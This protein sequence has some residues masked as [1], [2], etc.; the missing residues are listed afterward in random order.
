MS[1]NGKFANEEELVATSA[2]T[3]NWRGILIALL[4]IIVVCALIITAVVL[5]TPGNEG[6][7]VKGQRITL[8]DILGDNFTT[9]GF[10]GT[11][12]SDTEFAYRNEDGA[13]LIYNVVYQNSTVVLTNSSFR[14]KNAVHWSISA[15][16]KFV[17]VSHDVQKMY[18]YSYVAKYTVFDLE[19]KD[20][21]ELSPHPGAGLLLQYVTWAPKDNALVLVHQ[22]DIYYLSYARTDDIVRITNTGL[23]GT[24]WNGIPDWVY[25]E[26]IL[27]T[28][29]ALWFSDDGKMLCFATFNDT[30]VN[31]M[32]YVWYGQFDEAY[33]RIASVRYPKPGRPN[34]VV[35]LNVV[36]LSNP[37]QLPVPLQPPVFSQQDHYFTAVRWV[38]NGR[39]S[40]IWM[41]R[42][43]NV[44][45][46]TICKAS[47]WYCNE[48]Q[49]V[50]AEG[51]G[52]V[53]QYA[54]PLYSKDGTK[55][56]VIVPARDGPYGLFPQVALKTISDGKLQF[57]TH[58]KWEVTKILAYDEI[59]QFVYYLMAPEGK[60]GQRHMY[61]VAEGDIEKSGECLTCAMG[62]DC[63]YVTAKF[64]PD[65]SY[66]ILQC[67]GPGI[68]SVTLYST[69]DNR[70]YVEL[71]T[72]Y[73]VRET[74]A[75]KALPQVRTF[76]VPLDDGF[77]AYVRL[78]LPPGL[79]DEEITRYPL[80]VEVYG[81]P[82]SQMVSEKFSIGLGHYL[83]SQKDMIY[84]SIDGRGSGFQGNRMLFQ[85]YKRLG[86]VEVEDQIAV[87]KYLKDNLHFIDT[88]RVAIWGWSYGGYVTAMIMG[89]DTRV[90]NC[91]IS[92][93]P[94]TNWKYYDSVY[95]ERYMGLPT[96]QSN[97]IGY[98]KSD[99]LM[100]AANFRDKKYFLIHGTAD[101]NVH[102]H[103]SMMLTKALIQANVVFRTQMY[104]DENHSLASVK[105]HLYESMEDFLGECFRHEQ[106]E[107][108]GLR[109]PE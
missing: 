92:V 63:L 96:T 69:R 46:I 10:N 85:L 1:D 65:A 73:R 61:R 45:I 32:H 30:Q 23:E 95:T 19:N 55:Y 106:K 15:D 25:E 72:N 47:L 29:H 8:D 41:N 62:P 87:T 64:S 105:R 22:N 49:R 21:F 5:L 20:S 80:V 9:K 90:F 99:V 42:A 76:R 35:T 59:E 16:R 88:D 102:L 44:S 3:R 43:Q 2:S 107:E 103:Q 75:T 89:T 40:V 79:R 100:K 6:P 71:E 91:G 56:F 31:I 81:G 39:I 26:E 98:D 86:S 78:Y 37:D 17:L 28:N 97:E 51:E 52:W 109:N 84:A 4:V 93:A 82:G 50:E 60:P 33:S 83:S 24:I 58:G 104:P 27:S 36:N 77:E 11:W 13:L 7:R 70:T 57:L 101:D 18:R 94:V 108:I 68:P 48:S 14:E 34:P 38:D 53:D 74:I 12:I 54:P 66:Y 67:L